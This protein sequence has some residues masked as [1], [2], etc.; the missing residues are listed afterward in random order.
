[1]PI[2]P[3]PRLWGPRLNARTHG[4]ARPPNTTQIINEMADDELKDACAMLMNRDMLA[5]T[6]SDSFK[7]MGAERPALLAELMQSVAK[8]AVSPGG[9]KRK[10]SGEGGAG[11]P[12]CSTLTAKAVKKLKTQQLRNEL[13]QRGLST[14]GLKADLRER[15]EAAL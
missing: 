1:M 2:A 10:R 12:A 4:I 15:L 8:T 13:N 5:V 3:T 7:R 11:A 6:Q 9:R 14:H